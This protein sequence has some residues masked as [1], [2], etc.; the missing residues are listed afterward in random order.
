MRYI[1]YELNLPDT[2]VS[3]YHKVHEISYDLLTKKYTILVG[4][5]LTLEDIIRNKRP[6]ATFKVVLEEPLDLQGPLLE[7]LISELKWDEQKAIIK[8]L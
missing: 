4:S 6:R 2:S 3:K 7:L 5:W 1:E 8:E